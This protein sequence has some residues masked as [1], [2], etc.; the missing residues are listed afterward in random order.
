MGG[1][2]GDGVGGNAALR[3]VVAM[4]LVLA[5]TAPARGQVALP[6]QAEDPPAP[7]P[8]LGMI[9]G[10][11]W[12]EIAYRDGDAVAAIEG[13]API[14]GLA[15]DMPLAPWLF[16]EPRLFHLSLEEGDALRYGGG[17]HRR[18]Q[19]EFGVRAEVA[20]GAVRPYLAAALGGFFHI[21]GDRPADRDFATATYIGAA[22]VRVPLGDALELRGEAGY[23]TFDDTGSRL[24]PVLFALGWRF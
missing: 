2:V 16:L 10:L 6:P 4:A 21:D 20:L 1:G 5:A 12:Y 13:R 19:L 14:V 3:V 7:G 24:V 22:G 11:A 15:A 23:R 8:S 17:S 9:G 18:W